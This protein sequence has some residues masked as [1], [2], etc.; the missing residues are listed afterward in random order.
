M[1]LDNEENQNGESQFDQGQDPIMGGKVQDGEGDN[2]AE[3]TK[4]EPSESQEGGSPTQSISERL[5]QQ[6]SGGQ[7]EEQVVDPENPVPLDLSKLT[8]EQLQQLK[9]MLAA[10]PDRITR[11]KKNPTIKLRVF[12]GKVVTDISRAF[13]GLIDDPENNR[14]VE[15]THIKVTLHDEKTPRAILYREFMQLDQ[16]VCEVVSNRQEKGEIVEG[17]TISRETGRPVEMVVTTV[18]DWFTVKFPDSDLVAEELRG[19]TLEIEGKLANA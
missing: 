16:I 2:G 15:R 12:D 8:T 10:T 14:K 7:T 9:S 17:E 5:S 3:P 19:K 18:T 13:K 11:K 1:S 4:P 6:D